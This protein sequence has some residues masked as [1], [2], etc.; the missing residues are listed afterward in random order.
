MPL[1]ISK[2]FTVNQIVIG[3]ISFEWNETT[4]QVRFFASYHG[5]DPQG[6][7]VNGVLESNV[8]E[9]TIPRTEI[10]AEYLD[11][12]TRVW[13]YIRDQIHQNEGAM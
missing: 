2:T 8:I 11:G 10:P 6:N 7:A 9:F 4:D 1:P 5:I 13:T 3:P 12:L